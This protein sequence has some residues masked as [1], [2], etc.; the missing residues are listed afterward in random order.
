MSSVTPGEVNAAFYDAHTN[1]AGKLDPDLV[2]PGT[3]K[4]RLLTTLAHD[5]EYRKEWAKIRDHLQTLKGC[6]PP[7]GGG[8]KPIVGACAKAA[9][10]PDAPAYDA[11]AWNKDAG[12]LNSTNCYAYAMNSRTGHPAGGKPQPGEKSSVGSTLSCPSLTAAVLADGV[13]DDIVAAPR[14]AYQKKHKLPPPDKTG[15]YLVALVTTSNGSTMYDPKSDTVRYADYH[16]YRQDT[17]GAWSHKPG[18][19]VAR[20]VDSSGRPVD[21]P[22]TAD[23]K[24]SYGKQ[25]TK[26][27][28][29]EFVMDYDVFCG[30][31]YV[32]KGGA[33]VGK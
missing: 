11:D 7:K 30:Y 31:F 17:D 28:P 22:E 4:F 15:Y 9:P 2:D 13:P 32:K 20:R 12:V 24:T 5:A 14:C 21:N 25:P 6:S 10:K 16:W 19:D 8:A 3:G 29:K 33:G 27:G 23:R 1:S 26:I 18:H